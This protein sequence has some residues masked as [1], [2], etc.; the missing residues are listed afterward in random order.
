MKRGLKV[1]L[2]TVARVKAWSERPIPNEEGTESPL[3]TGAI[4][5]VV[6][7]FSRRWAGFVPQI[8]P[9]GP[10]ESIGKC[11]ATSF[12]W[13]SARFFEASRRPQTLSPE[14]VIL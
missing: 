1:D 5:C 6:N 10:L 7:G 4:C 9:V 2:T 3:V 12:G 13:L 8:V 14:A 11:S